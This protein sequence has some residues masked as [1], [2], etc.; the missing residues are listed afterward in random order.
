VRGDHQL[1]LLMAGDALIHK[2]ESDDQLRCVLRNAIQRL[3]LA[4]CQPFPVFSATA[5][6]PEAFYG[7]SGAIAGLFVASW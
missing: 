7:H 6:A 4:I 3:A 5:P 2:I 1:A